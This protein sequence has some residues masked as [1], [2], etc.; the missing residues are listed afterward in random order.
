MPRDEILMWRPNGDVIAWDVALG[1]SGFTTLINISPLTNEVYVP[2]NYLPA[3]GDELIFQTNFGGAVWNP[4]LGNN[5]FLPAPDFRASQEG[6]PG[7]FTGSASTD[8]IFLTTAR[9]LVVYDFTAGTFQTLFNLAPQWTLIG[10]ADLDG[11]GQAEVAISSP[12]GDYFVFE[13]G[14]GAFRSLISLPPSTGWVAAARGNYT[15]SAAEDVALLNT[16]T[17]AVVL[18]DV[19]LGVNG[20]QP[21]LTLNAGWGVA[22][23]FH[24][25]VDGDG[26]DD[27]LF[28]GPR[29]EYVMLGSSAGFIDLTNILAGNTFLGVG[30]VTG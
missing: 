10:A 17:G 6:I 30:D 19:T 8:G 4:R 9:D 1:A 18:W 14:T 16:Q 29:G 20:F 7:N 27:G 21:L 15:G 23:N 5:G 26:Y 24:G 13:P 25:D 3:A 22:S 28:F 12:Q 2:G 11:N